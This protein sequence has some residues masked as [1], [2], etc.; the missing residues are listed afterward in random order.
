MSNSTA[1]QSMSLKAAHP[2]YHTT[3]EIRTQIRELASTCPGMTLHTESYGALMMGGST[4]IDVVTIKSGSSKPTNKNFFLMGEH[5]REL[6]G[7]ETALH[8]VKS[9][10]GQTELSAKAKDVLL[11]NEFQIIVNANTKSRELVE[12]GDFC[13]R[14]NQNGV[15]LNRN[16]DQ[17]WDPEPNPAAPGDTNP[18]PRPFSEPETQM[19][20]K[21]V[22]AYD[23]HT[24]VTI[25]SGTLG[26]YMP[27]AHHV[28][29][30]ADRNQKE[31]M[32]IL[33]EVD[34]THC[35]C[36][37]G[38]AGK[39]VGYQCPGTCLD[40]IYEKLQTP[41][42]FAYEIYARPEEEASLKARWEE[43]LKASGG[44]AFYQI[45]A[46]LGHHDQ[47]FQFPAQ[48]FEIFNP[49]TEADYKE[50]IHTWVEAYLDT[51]AMCAEDLKQKAGN[52]T[53][54]AAAR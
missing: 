52:S 19:L 15:D 33:K 31:M 14:A 2:Y 9:L 18:G 35:Q 44:A 50:N 51:A 48:C 45:D 22:T 27:W 3:A 39:E 42:A 24:F 43:K 11:E 1:V 10:C 23:P 13:L 28:H 5:S 53:S 36:P 7:P 32:H 34:R 37:Y 54:G 49:G 12:Q 46:N 41:Y 4:S 38:A 17:N 29:E 25:H 30:L 6:I 8:L 47:E 21:L 16:W 20:K 40:W 26:M